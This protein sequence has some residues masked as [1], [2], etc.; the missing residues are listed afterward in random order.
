MSGL[1][2]IGVALASL[3][4]LVPLW[5]LLSTFMIGCSGCA[6]EGEYCVDL[7]C[8]EGLSCGFIE[9]QGYRCH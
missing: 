5:V 3:L 9:G 1:K 6:S 2:R 4:A 7:D 8:C